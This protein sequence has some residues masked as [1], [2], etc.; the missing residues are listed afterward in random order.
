MRIT[1]TASRICWMAGANVSPCQSPTMTRLESPMPSTTRPGARWLR[2][3]AVWPRTTGVRVWTGRTAEP[4][5][6][7]SV[8]PAIVVMRLI[9]S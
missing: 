9:A 7:R 8:W 6:S 3:A 1:C 5:W 2:V 4:T